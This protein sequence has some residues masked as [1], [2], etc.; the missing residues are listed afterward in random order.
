MWTRQFQRERKPLN[1]NA[2]DSS[3]VDISWRERSTAF[4]PIGLLVGDLEIRVVIIQFGTK[5]IEPS[6]RHQARSPS[7]SHLA[8]SLHCVTVVGLS[9]DA[10]PTRCSG[11]KFNQRWQ[12]ANNP[13]DQQ[14][15][16]ASERYYSQQHVT[17]LTL[18]QEQPTPTAFPAEG[19]RFRF[20]VP[21][22]EG[23]TRG[24]DC[25]RR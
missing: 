4:P 21:A 13:S 3:L 16:A 6:L 19:A 17:Q 15:R 20:V 25:E 18:P 23:D 8:L 10:R 7:N 14:Q 2:S 11:S 9:S 22:L 24:R 5:R 1:V 12:K